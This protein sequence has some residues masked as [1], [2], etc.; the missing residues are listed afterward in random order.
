[1]MGSIADRPDR[2]TLMR[3]SGFY[4]FA[5][6]ALNFL[7]HLFAAMDKQILGVV[8]PQLKMELMLTDSQLGLL[9]GAPFAICYSVLSI[10][11]AWLADTRFSRTGVVAVSLIAWSVLT[12]LC[13]LAGSFL[14]LFILRMG[15]GGGEAGAIPA[16]YSLLTDTTSPR[17]RT[18]AIA[19]CSIGVAAGQASALALG[20]WSVQELGWRTTYVL[21]GAPGVIVALLYY[22]IIKEPPRQSIA[23]S[24]G[25]NRFLTDFRT[26][27]T[28]PPFL[29]LTLSMATGT[30]IIFAIGAWMPSYLQRTYALTPLESGRALGATL[31]LVALVGPMGS[32][33]LADRLSVRDRTMML[34]LAA[35]FFALCGVSYAAAFLTDNLTLC[36]IL[37]GVSLLLIAGTAPLGAIMA[38]E[39]EPSLKA[40]AMAA[41]M[42]GINLIG[43]TLAPWI[44]GAISDATGSG[45]GQ[46]GLRWGLVALAPLLI[47]AALC[48]WL[49]ANI[50]RRR[51]META[52]AA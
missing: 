48:A 36:Y 44:V 52:P 21:V 7:V 27:L 11:I 50:L 29:L 1:M 6:L 34:R 4:L 16:T 3:Y 12:A 40:S 46:D 37:T 25:S 19:M 5:V 24:R 8:L 49:T 23:T 20:G 10:P 14:L 26:L 28:S 39:I 51:P 9:S 35:L 31:G 38:Q 17:W 42:V 33:W 15:V 2:G 13:G 30:S 41:M 47:V 43:H 45:P 22:F 32:A 18:R